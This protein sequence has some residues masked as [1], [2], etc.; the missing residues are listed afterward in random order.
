[1]KALRK[2]LAVAAVITIMA[3]MTACG[4]ESAEEVRE[5]EH[6]H[7]YG[8]YL[9]SKAATCEEAGYTA[10]VSDYTFDDCTSLKTIYIPVTCNIS[11]TALPQGVQ[12]I[13]AEY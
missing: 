4:S 12:V 1:M 2:V 7:V 8:I 11:S 9:E 10:Q 6:K 13:R 5:E 3:A